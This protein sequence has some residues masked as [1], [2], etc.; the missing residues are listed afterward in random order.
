M[1]S[2]LYAWAAWVVRRRGGMI[3]AWLLLLAVV[4]GLGITMHGT[5]SNSFSV[6]GIE[7]QRAQDLLKQKFPA[8]AG[9]VVRI[10]IET[11]KG[12]RLTDPAE[13]QALSQSLQQ[14]AKVPG[15]VNVMTPAMTRAVSA[16]K[17]I[18]YADVR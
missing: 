16:D 3:T 8:A 12:T 13:E 18:A 11:P 17:S 14:A 7:S 10:V 5:I 4:G 1:A 2:R 6:P 9:G 15:V